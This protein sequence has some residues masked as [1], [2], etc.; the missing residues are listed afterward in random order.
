M[1]WHFV[2]WRQFWLLF[3]EKMGDFLFK[4]SGQLAF[5]QRNFAD[6]LELQ[7]IQKNP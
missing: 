6:V 4:S 7:G 3:E 2:A 5:L 1:F